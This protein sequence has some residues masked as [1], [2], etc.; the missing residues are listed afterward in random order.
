MLFNLGYR[1]DFAENDEEGVQ[2]YKEYKESQNPFDA[3]IMELTIPGKMGARD[4]ILI[5]W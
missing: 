5:L 2:L 1:V 4:A 3:V